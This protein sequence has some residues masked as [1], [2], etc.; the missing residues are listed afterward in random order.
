MTRKPAEGPSPRPGLPTRSGA[1]PAAVRETGAHRTTDGIL[2]LP[3]A[4]P[5]R[6][7]GAAGGSLAGALG[8]G[9]QPG[10]GPGV[11]TLSGLAEQ[12]IQALVLEYGASLPEKVIRAEVDGT[13]GT[14]RRRNVVPLRAEAVVRSRLDALREGRPGSPIRSQSGALSGP[15]ARPRPAVRW[16]LPL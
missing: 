9:P 3:G 7:S 6:R 4:G 15:V 10:P 11:G 13:L 1:V 2:A 5:A 12:I 14:S 8:T 16:Q